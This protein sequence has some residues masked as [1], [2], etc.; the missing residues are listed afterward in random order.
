MRAS[1]TNE[2]TGAFFRRPLAKADAL[3]RLNNA[4]R[5]GMTLTPWSDGLPMWRAALKQLSGATFFHCE[6]WIEALRGSY[7]L[8]LEIATLHREGDLRAAAVFARSKGLFGTRLV[9]LPFSDCGEPL[10]SDDQSRT[11]FLRLL[12]SSRQAGSIEIRGAAGPAPWENVDCFVHWTLDLKRP[13]SE[14]SAGFGRTVRSGI[15]RGVKDNILIDRGTNAAYLARFFELQ[16]RTRRRLGIPPQPFKF[17]ST[18]HEKFAQRGDCEVWFATRDGRD[19]AGLVLLRNGD[20]FCYKWG[21]R[22]ES[23]HPGANHL[24]VA[25]MLE[26]HAG[27]LGSIDFGRCDTRNRGLVRSKADLGCVQRPLPYAFFPRA[28]HRISSE[29]LS[30]PAQILSSVWKKLPLPVTR[31]LGEA[32]YRYI[33]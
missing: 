16:L 8:K 4:V 13:F 31:V 20:Q 9:S 30:G 21:A 17:F 23:C 15:K 11:E 7:P 27:K 14:I 29:V 33:A 32:L 19:E 18:V 3:G 12:A 2:T 28:P 5:D 6:P 1:L 10:A 22:A 25:S 26:A 24:L